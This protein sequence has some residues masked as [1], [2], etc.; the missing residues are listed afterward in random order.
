MLTYED[1]SDEIEKEL[2]KRRK[3]W[4]LGVLRWIDWEDIAQIIRAHI[5]KKWHLWDQT[6]KLA[7]WVQRIASNQIYNQFRNL[8]TSHARPCV[9]CKFAVGEDGC[10]ETVSNLQ[11]EECPLYEKWSKTKKYGYHAKIPLELEHHAQEVNNKI[12]DTINFKETMERVMVELEKHMSPK[13]LEAF[14]VLFIRNLPE[15]EAALF[16][17]LRGK[18]NGTQK[19]IMAAHRASLAEEAK[20]IIAE[21]DI[22]EYWP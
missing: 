9:Q 7:P 20:R 5:A 19:K 15:E 13:R 10:S 1:C 11:C 12:D 21:S 14:K 3:K 4:T 2:R 8:Y 18:N 16:L 22:S 6:R 17:K